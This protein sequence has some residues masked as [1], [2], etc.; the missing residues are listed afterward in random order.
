MG[1]TTIQ[2]GK[3]TRE[4]L[5]RFGRKDATYDQIIKNLMKAAEI[6]KFYYDIEYILE[7]EEFVPLD[8]I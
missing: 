8:K 3:E 2:I 7:N 6:K 4:G 5:K 1:L